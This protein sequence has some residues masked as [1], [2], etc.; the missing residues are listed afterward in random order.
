[1]THTQHVLAVTTFFPPTKGGLPNHVY[2]ITR[3]LS[4]MGTTLSLITPKLSNVE[5]SKYYEHF[6]KVYRLNSF[7]LPGWPYPTLQSVGIPKDLGST[8]RIIPGVGF[9]KSAVIEAA[10]CFSSFTI[11]V[12]DVTSPR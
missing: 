6:K 3:N 8:F 5:T 9:L 11:C 2:H 4:E 12:V 1:M 7:F 10:K